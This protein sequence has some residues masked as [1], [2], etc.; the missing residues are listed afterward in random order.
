MCV[1]SL[2]SQTTI[3]L[4]HCWILHPLV[5]HFCTFECAIKV[6]HCLRREGWKNPEMC[7]GSWA[8][9][10]CGQPGA[11]ALGVKLNIWIFTIV[12]WK[13]Y[14]K[15]FTTLTSSEEGNPTLLWESPCALVFAGSWYQ[16]CPP[17]ACH[18]VIYTWVKWGTVEFI[19]CPRI[20][21]TK[22]EASFLHIRPQTQL[23][24][25]RTHRNNHVL[26]RIWTWVPPVT[27]T[28]HYPAR[29]SVPR[30]EVR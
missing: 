18:E 6:T 12:A 10:E 29:P 2:K 5:W 17:Q 9:G 22:R 11:G 19:C 25:V 23:R 14:Q 4:I 3:V 21:H 1:T 27:I 16:L 28:S 7:Q 20:L 15:Q 24:C 13:P 26:C 8:V 30:Q